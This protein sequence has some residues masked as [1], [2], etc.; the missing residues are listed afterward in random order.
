MLLGYI[1]VAGYGQA[2]FVFFLDF[3]PKFSFSA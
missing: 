1:P 3:F 2:G